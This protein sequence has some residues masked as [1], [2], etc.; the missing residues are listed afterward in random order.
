MASLDS[1]N[2]TFGIQRS[3]ALSGAQQIQ[4]DLNVT[5]IMSANT[6]VGIMLQI[7]TDS[8]TYGSRV[9]F[10]NWRN[11]ILV[12]GRGSS[13]AF[14]NSSSD[15]IFSF[16]TYYTARILVGETGTTLSFLSDDTTASLYSYFSA[17]L[18]IADLPS[19]FDLQVLQVA[20]PGNAIADAYINSVSVVAVPEP[21]TYALVAVGLFALVLRYRRSEVVAAR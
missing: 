11:G 10:Q 12:D 13:G 9:V 14:S 20:G 1:S 7:G 19:S 6:N 3:V 5:V 15:G 4:I 8:T 2:A 16:G 17:N 21:A 18:T